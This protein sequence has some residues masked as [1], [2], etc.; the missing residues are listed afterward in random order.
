MIRSFYHRS[1]ADL[2]NPDETTMRQQLRADPWYPNLVALLYLLS[3]AV[4]VSLVLLITTRIGNGT[5]S[6]NSNLELVV[7][8]YVVWLCFNFVIL[9]VSTLLFLDQDLR[10]H[11][12]ESSIGSWL[13]SQKR[14][15]VIGWTVVLVILVGVS[16]EFCV[17]GVSVWF[18][19]NIL[20]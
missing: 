1:E 9:L 17:L 12:L 2:S 8:Y 10:N 19:T 20:E 18:E 14:L 15:S 11:W 13:L 16:V 4:G 3:L 7:W 5:I 6:P